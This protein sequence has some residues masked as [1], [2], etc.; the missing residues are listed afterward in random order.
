MYI[1]GCDLIGM[2]C[3][4]CLR[5]EGNVEGGETLVL[6]TLPVLEELRQKYPK[7]FEILCTVPTSFQRQ[8]VLR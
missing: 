1:P 7:Q 4:H 6:D 3:L 5:F 8:T 2:F